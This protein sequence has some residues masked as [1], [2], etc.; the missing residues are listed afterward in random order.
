MK[1][2]LDHL[3]IAATDL[4]SGE[5]W[6]RD[7]LGVSLTPGGQHP[8]WGTHNRL[9]QLGSGVY[10]ELIAA[11]PSQRQPDAPRPFM[12]DTP[13]LKARMKRAP[14]LVHWLCRTDD[15]DAAMA[16]L[17]YLQGRPTPMT[18]GELNWRICIASGGR[19]AA[20]GLLPTLIQWDVPDRLHPSARLPDVGVKLE[21]LTVRGLR[22]VIERRPAVRSPVKIDWAVS[23]EPGLSARFSTPTGTVTL[24][25]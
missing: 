4:D 16:S 9:L 3:V 11:D 23:D 1:I 14:V 17:Q 7:R 8:G 22:E 10:L 15:M 20:D 18:R 5:A 24:G 13:E 25:R 2:E 12:L 21:S 19:P 6:L